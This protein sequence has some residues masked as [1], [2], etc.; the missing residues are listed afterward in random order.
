MGRRATRI[1]YNTAF[2]VCAGFLYVAIFGT[3]GY[4]FRWEAIVGA[5]LMVS[6]GLIYINYSLLD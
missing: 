3:L 5:I 6:M 4:A 2:I 1:Q